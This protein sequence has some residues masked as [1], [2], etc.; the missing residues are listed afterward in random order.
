MKESTK[1]N[2]GMGLVLVFFIIV[3]SMSFIVGALNQPLPTI[4]DNK[5]KLCKRLAVYNWYGEFKSMD[6]CINNIVLN[7]NTKV[8]R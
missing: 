7:N 1:D 6:D 3:Y 8:T 2:I 5:V 4:H